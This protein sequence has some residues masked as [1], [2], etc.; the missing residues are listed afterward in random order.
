MQ[1]AHEGVPAK[2]AAIDLRPVSASAPAFLQ[3]LAAGAFQHFNLGGIF[4]NY[5]LPQ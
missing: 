3:Y 2:K 4:F 5:P 1:R